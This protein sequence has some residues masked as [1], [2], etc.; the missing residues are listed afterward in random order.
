MGPPEYTPEFKTTLYNYG[1]VMA[2]IISAVI[3][4][5]LYFLIPVP[6]VRMFNFVMVISGLMNALLNG[7]PLVTS[8]VSNDG[9]NEKECRN[10]AEARRAFWTQL[11][12]NELLSKGVALTDMP[13]ELFSFRP[14]KESLLVTGAY[15]A[16]VNRYMNQNDYRKCRKMM[17][18]F[19]AGDY[20]IDPLHRQLL[21]TDLLFCRII[22]GEDV[23]YDYHGLTDFFAKM[24]TALSVIRTQ[25]A[26]EKLAMQNIP[27]ADAYLNRFEKQA[28][29]YPYARDV[30]VERGLIA[31]TDSKVYNKEKV[32][33]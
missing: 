8:T 21:E 25:Y 1:G 27:M 29:V 14:D 33:K 15:L 18:E 22:D 12:A 5:I 28:A 23:A 3:C 4:L 19:L 10:N 13:E 20:M 30:E 11:K 6:L 9:H 31:L 24:K 26:Y 17:E 7:I 16:G 2:N 32:G